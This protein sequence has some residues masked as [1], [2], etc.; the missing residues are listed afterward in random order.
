MNNA[1]EYKGSAKRFEAYMANPVYQLTVDKEKEE[2]SK[3][4]DHVSK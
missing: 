2:E 3:S 1:P 4:K